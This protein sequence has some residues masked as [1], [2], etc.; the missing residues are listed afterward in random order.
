[1]LPFLQR[2]THPP[3]STPYTQTP[4]LQLPPLLHPQSQTPSTTKAPN[5]PSPQQPPQAP[6]TVPYPPP[7][8]TDVADAHRA[9]IPSTPSPTAPLLPRAPGKTVARAT[10]SKGIISDCL[11]QGLYHSVLLSPW[12]PTAPSSTPG[13]C[14]SHSHSPRAQRPKS[15]AGWRGARRL[16]SGRVPGVRFCGSGMWWG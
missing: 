11:T 15:R 9:H 16:S 12:K 7:Y 3:F 8:K 1:M 4:Q 5:C 6:P 14:H 13:T 2:A 10:N